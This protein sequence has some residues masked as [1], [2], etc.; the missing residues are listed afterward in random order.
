MQRAAHLVGVEMEV[1]AD[2]GI[3]VRLQRKFN[4]TYSQ[5]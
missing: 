2:K 3:Q 4:K 5:K 1:V